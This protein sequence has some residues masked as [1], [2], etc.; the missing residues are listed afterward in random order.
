MTEIEFAKRYVK[1]DHIQKLLREFG[2]SFIEM[3]E[4]VIE[5]RKEMRFVQRMSY[6]ELS[7]WIDGFQAALKELK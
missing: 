3:G 7:A 4:N 1:V 2:Y 5:L 6:I